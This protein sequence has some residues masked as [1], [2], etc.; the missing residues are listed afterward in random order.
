[1]RKLVFLFMLITCSLGL[2]AQVNVKDSLVSAPLIGFSFGY[3]Y[4]G[5]DMAK[6]FGPN[7]DIG[8]TFVYKA[9][10]GWLYGGHASYLFGNNIEEKGIFDSIAG[11]DGSLIN[12]NGQI[13]NVR[14]YQRGWNM[15]AGGG[16]IFDIWNLN[17][18]SGPMVFAGV[19]FLQHKLRIEDVGNQ[20]PQLAGDYK[21][22]YDRLTNGIAFSEFIGYMFLGS[23]RKVNFFAGFELT[24]AFT[25]SRRSW[26][27]DLMRKDVTKRTDLLYG[28]RAGWI[29]PLYK[30]M[31]KEYYYY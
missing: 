25:Q 12:Q 28:F 3:H 16:K 11:P 20:S 26:D 15:Y 14:T 31:P 2:E 21:K 7:S 22:G 18:N 4:P 6:R 19:G 23:N 29:L 9:K 17:P 24:Q 8:L 27:Y 13:A 30:R 5:A 1:M 10:K